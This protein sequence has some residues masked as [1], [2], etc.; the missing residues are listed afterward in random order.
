MRLT[1]SLK[2]PFGSTLFDGEATFAS[3]AYLL[4]GS[5]GASQFQPYLR[6]TVNSPT[7]GSSSSLTE[8]GVN[9]IIAGHNMKLNL[10]FTTGDASLTGAKGNDVF[11]YKPLT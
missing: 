4:P 5:T 3:F 1:C 9:Y 7:T 11:R 10:N 2:K 6:V 8:T